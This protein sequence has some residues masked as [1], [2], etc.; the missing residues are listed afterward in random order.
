MECGY[1]SRSFIDGLDLTPLQT[2]LTKKAPLLEDATT[3]KR[4]VSSVVV[5]LAVGPKDI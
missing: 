5:R 4:P 2:T 1:A 3:R